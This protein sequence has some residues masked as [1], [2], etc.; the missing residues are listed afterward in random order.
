MTPTN[1]PV[2]AVLFDLDDTLYDHLHSARQ[3]LIGLTERYPYMKA[4]SLETLERRFSDVL[5]S[6]HTSM[7]AGQMNQTEARC[8][9]FQHLFGSF[10]VE[11]SEQQALQDYARFREDYDASCRVVAGSHSVLRQLRARDIRLAVVTNNMVREQIKKLNRLGLTDYFE[12]VSIS[13]EVG[14]AKPDSRI[15]LTTLQRLQLATHDVVMVGDSLTT[16]IAGAMALN[17]ASVWLK[18]QPESS[19]QPPASVAT[20]EGDLSDV[21]H[22]IDTILASSDR[23]L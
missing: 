3:G 15:Y 18:R 8:R 14:A 4:V 19:A 12:V 1:S 16:D 20:I 11:I 2:K 23:P 7:L 5:E 6:T 21:E 9:R 10:D 17:I 13:E 22:C